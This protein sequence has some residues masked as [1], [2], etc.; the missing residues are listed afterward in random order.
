MSFNIFKL[1]SNK[2]KGDIVFLT[3]SEDNEE[4][5]LEDSDSYKSSHYDN[6]FNSQSAYSNSIVTSTS[7]SHTKSSP[8]SKQINIPKEKRQTML[9]NYCLK[10]YIQNSIYSISFV[11]KINS[12]EIIRKILIGD[13]I[14]INLFSSVIFELFE[15]TGKSWKFEFKSYHLTG[16]PEIEEVTFETHNT[17]KTYLI[18]LI[19][20]NKLNLKSGDKFKFIYDVFGEKWEIHCKIES[21]LTVKE[22]INKAYKNKLEKELNFEKLK[23]LFRPILISGTNQAPPENLGGP[24]DFLKFL[25]HFEDPFNPITIKYLN[26]YEELYSKEGEEDS[27]VNGKLIGS[28]MH[29]YLIDFDF[30]YIQENLGK[31]NSLKF[32][33]KLAKE[34]EKEKG[35]EINSKLSSQVFDATLLTKDILYC[36][37]EEID[38]NSGDDSINEYD[39]D[40]KDY[41]NESDLRINTNYYQ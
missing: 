28:R 21:N 27:K 35:I 30:E 41:I 16:A 6:S 36:P 40:T 39:F 26:Y 20:L 19:Y 15:F 24:P 38:S 13:N 25:K 2:D 10:N 17:K 32:Y 18:Y 3:D 29:K 37:K 34:K 4:E 9:V 1:G 31:I 7:K 8:I 22:I 11:I 33:K 14:D 23:S 5:E 12:H